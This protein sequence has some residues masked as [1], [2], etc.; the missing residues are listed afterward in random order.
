MT[1]GKDI[2]SNAESVLQFALRNKEFIILAGLEI[3]TIAI[4]LKKQRAV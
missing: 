1:S 3:V 2:L 4:L